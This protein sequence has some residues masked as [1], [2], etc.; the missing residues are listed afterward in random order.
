[1]ISRVKHINKLHESKCLNVKS[2]QETTGFFPVVSMCLH[3]PLIHVVT[4]TKSL[5]TS[6]V[7][8]TWALTKISV[9]HPGVVELK[10]RTI[11]F[12]LPQST[13]QAPQEAPQSPRSPKWCQ[14]PRVTSYG[15][16]LSKNRSPTM[17]AHKLLSTQVLSLASWMIEWSN[18]WNVKL[19]VA[20]NKRM[21]VLVLPG[22]K[23]LQ[24]DPLEG[25][26]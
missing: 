25:Y 11:F 2:G 8:E 9:H 6:Q 21:S 26:I 19:K 13:W 15:L 5:V 20:L 3:T 18:E 4:L 12:G 24:N 16:H 1:M 17:D 23:R 7:T 14:S 10:P 22:L